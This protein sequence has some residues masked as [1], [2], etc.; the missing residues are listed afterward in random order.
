MS[1]ATTRMSAEA[2]REAI[3][4]AVMPVFARKGFANT[5]TKDLAEAAK[6]SEALIYKH[7]PSKES[8]YAEIQK[9]GCKGCDP[10]LRRLTSLQP[11]TTTLVYIIYYVVRGNI[12][13]S[14]KE[15]ASWETRHRM[16][17]NSCLEDG[18]F[19]R[20]LFQNR[21]AENMP[22]IEACMAAA[23]AAGEMKGCQVT[24]RN[25]LIFTHHVAV[26]VATMHLPEKPV[27]DYKGSKQ[28]VLHQ[29]MLYTLRGIGLTDEAIARYYDPKA[30]ELFFGDNE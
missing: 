20:F 12:L 14:C 13:G 4:H 8:L 17:L 19:T 11:S 15:P 29:A 10:M 22:Y 16:V 21:F 9:H 27:I 5:T 3:V 23:E 6:V 26:M 1:E 28:D 24:H 2:R 7:F 30:M 18:S 25:R